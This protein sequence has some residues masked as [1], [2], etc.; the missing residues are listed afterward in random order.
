M[1]YHNHSYCDKILCQEKKCEKSY[2]TGR[3]DSQEE[4]LFLVLEFAIDEQMCP[5]MQHSYNPFWPW[6]RVW[7]MLA[8]AVWLVAP[9]CSNCSIIYLLKFVTKVLTSLSLPYRIQVCTWSNSEQNGLWANWRGEIECK[10]QHM[11]VTGAIPCKF[12][13]MIMFF[14]PFMNFATFPM[15]PAQSLNR[16]FC[17]AMKLFKVHYLW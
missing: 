14:L 6:P 9:F 10:L 15:L 5:K 16:L 12:T 8:M 7:H 3:G 1:C 13:G 17:Y 2:E 11:A 4:A